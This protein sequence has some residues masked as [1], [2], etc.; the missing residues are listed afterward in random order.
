MADLGNLVREQHEVVDSIEEHI[1]K[2][3]VQI[4]AGHVNLQKARNAQTA[5]YPLV[6]AAIGSVA[7]G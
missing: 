7:V 2:S 5:K 3:A 4:R 6:A 1:E